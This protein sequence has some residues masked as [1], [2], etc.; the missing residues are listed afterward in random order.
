MICLCKAE[1]YFSL[2][3]RIFWKRSQFFFNL[4]H[5]RNWK[6]HMN[7]CRA[8]QFR[9]L[10]E[11]KQVFAL[12]RGQ[13]G[14][15]QGGILFWGFGVIAY[16]FGRGRAKGWDL[17]SGSFFSGAVGRRLICRVKIGA[18]GFR[19]PFRGFRF[20]FFCNGEGKRAEEDLIGRTVLAER[21]M[22]SKVPEGLNIGDLWPFAIPFEEVSEIW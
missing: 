13:C 8:L 21:R 12:G 19:G 11:R 16:C 7:P 22:A 6:R 9:Y 4:A 3:S 18:W 10:S 20:G 17:I 15:G 2:S 5:I 14:G 1:E